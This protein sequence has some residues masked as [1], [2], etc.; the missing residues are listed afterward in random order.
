MRLRGSDP[1]QGQAEAQ[2]RAFQINAGSLLPFRDDAHN[3]ALAS[4]DAAGFRH[5]HNI[6]GINCSLVLF[7]FT[8][9]LSPLAI[10]STLRCC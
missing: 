8:I 3:A 7:M 10:K 4:L 1:L 9:S 5:P 6:L 2:A